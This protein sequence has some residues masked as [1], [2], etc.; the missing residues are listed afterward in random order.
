MKGKALFLLVIFLLHTVVG[1]ACSLHLG[2]ALQPSPSKGHEH[3]SHVHSADHHHPEGQS[4]HYLAGFDSL[5]APAD[6]VDVC[7]QDEVEEFS[8]LDKNLIHVG[9]IDLKAPVH[10]LLPSFFYCFDQLAIEQSKTTFFITDR[11][12]P[13]SV[14]IRIS[15]SSFLI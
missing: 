1:L 10:L 13:S 14:D 7:C 3:A 11:K 9:K 4:D 15:I 5:Q 6:N 12:P 8:L 2:S